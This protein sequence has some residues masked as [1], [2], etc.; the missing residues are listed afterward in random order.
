MVLVD[1]SV[2]VD[3]FKGTQTSQVS[4]LEDLIQFEEDLCISGVILAEV[5]QGIQ[6]DIDYRKTL[7]YF[8]ALIYLPMGQSSFVLASTLHRGARRMGL[9]IRSTIDCLIAA[10]AIH[11]SVPLLQNDR[12]FQAIARCSRLKL[13]V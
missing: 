1:T 9:T 2:W 3:F 6:S 5:L 12:D 4:I 8:E 13:L 7:D 10:C 11:H